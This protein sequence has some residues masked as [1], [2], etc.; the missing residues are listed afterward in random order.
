MVGTTARA[1]NGAITGINVTPLVD[2]TF[3]LL[4]VFMVTAKMIV[5]HTSL[6][7]DLPKAAT[8]GEVQEIFSVTLTA[9]GVTQ[10]NGETLT[11]DDE[12][13]PRARSAQSSNKELRAVIKADGSV[14]HD[15]VMHVLDLLRQGGVSK[16]GFGVVAVAAPT[17]SGSR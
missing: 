12:I 7:V 5:S 16:V 11:A 8:A 9:S 17:G 15:R 6:P 13:L 1:R 4:I 14:P 10:V 2:I 3:V